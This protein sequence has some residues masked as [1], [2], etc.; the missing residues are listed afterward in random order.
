[1]RGCKKL[2][3]INISPGVKVFHDY[4]IVHAKCRGYYFLDLISIRTDEG[5]KMCP[6]TCAKK[7][8]NIIQDSALDDAVHLNT[9]TSEA[10]SL[11]NRIP[12]AN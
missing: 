9:V 3:T 8:E 12:P 4:G 6:I 7:T 1:V 11:V 10:T 2:K 5:A